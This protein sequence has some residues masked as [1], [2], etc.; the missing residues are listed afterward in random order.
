MHPDSM[1]THVHGRL[2]TVQNADE[3]YDATRSRYRDDET[4]GCEKSGLP[5][6]CWLCLSLSLSD[7]QAHTQTDTS[8]SLSLI[9]TCTHAHARSDRDTERCREAVW[10]I[11]QLPRITILL[12]YHIY[13]RRRLRHHLLLVILLYQGN[14]PPSLICN[15]CI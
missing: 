14:N 11:I 6:S 2:T 9:H 3:P 12:Y 7:V 5:F 4:C 15:R 8:L 13:L 10:S 1:Y